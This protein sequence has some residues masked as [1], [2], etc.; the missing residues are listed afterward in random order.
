MQECDYSVE[1]NSVDSIRAGSWPTGKMGLQRSQ[2]LLSRAGRGACSLLLLTAVH[3]VGRGEGTGDAKG[4][5]A[6]QYRHA[7]PGI[8]GKSVEVLLIGP[9]VFR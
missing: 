4:L 6:R 7:V 8:K 9:G 5:H 3:G 1:M 2:F